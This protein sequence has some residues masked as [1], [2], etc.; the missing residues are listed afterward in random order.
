MSK[1]KLVQAL[2]DFAQDLR[3]D[4][5]YAAAAVVVSPLFGSDPAVAGVAAVLVYALF[6]AAPVLLEIFLRKD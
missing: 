5:R 2:R 1:N 3:R 6:R 4:A